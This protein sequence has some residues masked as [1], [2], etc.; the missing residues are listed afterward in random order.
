MARIIVL[1]A[2]PLGL[3]SQARGKPDAT[4]VR[5]LTRFPGIDARTW[6]TITH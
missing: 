5:H 3:A 6:E 4:N 2:G 1:D